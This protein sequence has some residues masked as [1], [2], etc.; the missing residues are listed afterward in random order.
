MQERIR[1]RKRR[2][3]RCKHIIK[4]TIKYDLDLLNLKNQDDDLYKQCPECNVILERDEKENR[5][6][7]INCQHD[8]CWL[9]M[10][11]YTNDH[12]ANYSV[13]GCPGMQYSK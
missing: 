3:Q 12:Y 2:L 11:A 5:K 1:A 4:I 7:C 10:N 9:C 8:F 13:A 6:I